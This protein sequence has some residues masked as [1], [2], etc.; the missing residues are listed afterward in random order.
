MQ[1]IEQ[2]IINE[3][4]EVELET[5]QASL[6]EQRGRLVERTELDKLAAKIRDSWWTELASTSS[7]VLARFSDLPVEFRARLKQ[8]ID[9][10]LGKAAERVRVAMTAK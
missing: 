2:D 5:A 6:D 8:S 1:L 3:R 10:E 7:L 4:R 9:Q